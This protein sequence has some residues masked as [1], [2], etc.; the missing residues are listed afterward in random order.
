[1]VD[2]AQGV[3][4]VAEGASVGREGAGKGLFS[5]VCVRRVLKWSPSGEMKTWVLCM[6]LRNALAWMIRSLSRWKSLRTPSGG[7]GLGRPALCS[8]GQARVELR[9]VAGEDREFYAEGGLDALETRIARL[10]R[11]QCVVEQVEDPAVRFVPPREGAHAPDHTRGGLKAGEILP[12]TV[13]AAQRLRLGHGIERPAVVG[14]E[15]DAGERFEAGSET[16]LRTPDALRDCR[17]KPCLR[18][19]EVQDP[20][21]LRVADRT[22]HDPLTL[23]DRHP[24]PPPS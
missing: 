10:Q 7:S 20:V 8:A 3:F 5:R 23:V 13:E 24:R 14:D 9:R 22:Q 16:G 12:D 6:S 15:V 4:V 17:E 2:D 18:G 19:V 11:V 21:R 1:M